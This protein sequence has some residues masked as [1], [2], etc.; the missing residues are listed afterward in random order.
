LNFSDYL[1]DLLRAPGYKPPMALTVR[2]ARADEIDWIN[3]QYDGV[4]FIHSNLDREIVA[5]AE[6][7][8]TKAGLG[9]LVHVEGENWELGGMYVLSEFR[10][11]GIADTIV[12]FLLS[13]SLPHHQVFCLPFSHLR[14]FYARFGFAPCADPRIVPEEISKK[15]AWCNETYEHE[16]L[17]FVLVR[18]INF[19]R[20]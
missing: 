12:R 7:D 4:G 3:Q 20:R 18:K 16:T 13:C 17:L 1:V 8:G 2:K 14:Q 10:G 19:E 6:H 9:R 11:L 15:H 5:I